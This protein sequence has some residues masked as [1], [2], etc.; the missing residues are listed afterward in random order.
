VV[1]IK[2]AVERQEPAADA[3]LDSILSA[4]GRDILA[5]GMGEAPAADHIG[6]RGLATFTS[7]AVCIAP[8]ASN[9]LLALYRAGRLEDARREAEPF[10][11]FERLRARLGG[12]QVLNDAVTAAGVAPMGPQLPMISSVPAA[13]MDKVKEAVNRLKEA[14]RSAGEAALAGSE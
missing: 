8:S 2:Y 7:R 9:R 5:S 12:I 1:F 3:Y 13:A 11:E 14:D 10:L 6:K 4:V